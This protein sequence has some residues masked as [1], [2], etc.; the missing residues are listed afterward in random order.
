MK[1]YYGNRLQ[2]LG[3][4]TT[5]SHINKWVA[6]GVAGEDVEPCTELAIE[7]S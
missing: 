5:I 2:V 3:F 4:R 1:K 7:G 6:F